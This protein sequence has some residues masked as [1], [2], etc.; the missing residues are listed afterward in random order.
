MFKLM[1]KKIIIFLGSKSLLNWTYDFLPKNGDTSHDS[2]YVGKFF[3]LLFSS[4]DFFPKKKIISFFSK[5]T[6]KSRVS[7]CNNFILLVLIWVKTV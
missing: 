1:A 3:M 6:I 4:P 2:L 7:N 5:N